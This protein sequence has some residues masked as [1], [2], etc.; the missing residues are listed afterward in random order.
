MNKLLNAGFKRLKKDKV[1]WFS[2]IGFMIFGIVMC[3]INFNDV[4]QYGKVVKTESVVFTFTNV[5][6]LAIA[7]FTCLFVGK[8]YSDGTIRNKII[9]GHNR[10]PIYFSNLI[11]SIIVGMISS[12]IFILVTLTIGIPLFGSFTI[13]IS[14]IILAMIDMIF[15]IIVYSSMFNMITLLCTNKTISIVL[16]ILILL[17]FLV[18]SL[19]VYGRLSEPEYIPQTVI[20]YS[21]NT[22]ITTTDGNTEMEMEMVQNPRYLNDEQRKSYQFIIDVLPTGQ[23]LQI[24]MRDVSNIKIL[25]VYSTIILIVLNS[26]GCFIFSKKDL[27]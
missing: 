24:S 9:I 21:G 4:I 27:K 5:I 18:V 10:K 6:G 15:V 1:F 25:A 2:S 12:I 8:E 19:F 22:S 17:G 7:I 14:M 16:S 11:I 3:L 13:P 26:I 23:A 20:T